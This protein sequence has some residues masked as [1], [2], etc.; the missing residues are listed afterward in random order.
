M[1]FYNWPV[2]FLFLPLPGLLVWYFYFYKRPRYFSSIRYPDLK[3]LKQ[4]GAD[5]P[6]LIIRKNLIAL[7]LL[8]LF[9]VILALA[10]PQGGHRITDREAEG[11]DI[12]LVLDISGTMQAE[13]FKPQNRLHVAKKVIADFIKG[14]KTDRLGLV[15]F[16]GESY[17]ASPLT[18]DYGIILEQLKALKMGSIQDG[19]AIG[20]AIANAVNRLQASPSRTRVIILLTDG[21]NN[22]GVI[23]PMTAA[24]AAAAFGIRIYTI[25]AGKPG[26]AP[27]PYTDPLGRKGYYRNPD[28]SLAMTYLDEESLKKIA[29]ITDG[30]YYHAADSDTLKQVYRKIDQ[31]EKS[32]VRTKQV[33]FYTENFAIFLIPALIL[34][35]AHTVLD[36]LILVKVP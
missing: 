31:M 17:T 18:L 34:L 14:R 35:L 30:R 21:Q 5:T 20:M 3:R 26:G 8:S 1:R 10:R 15:A 36:Q 4:S 29:Q 13:D 2:L 9:F 25:G 24:E 12:M 28:N 32:R 19:T 11:I 23:D 22:A 16:S 7:K 6:R 27:I 33:V